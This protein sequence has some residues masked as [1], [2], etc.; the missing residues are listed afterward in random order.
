MKGNLLVFVGLLVV[1]AA[2]VFH[3]F[4]GRYE[5]SVGSGET[6]RIG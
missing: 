3:S 2:I 4:A 6:I 1:A 5:V